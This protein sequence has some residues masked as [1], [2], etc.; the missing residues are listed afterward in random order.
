[1]KFP[2]EARRQNASLV[3]TQY[4]VSPLLKGR[5]ISTVHD[6]SFLVDPYWFTPKDV[7]LLRA[8]VRAAAR[9]CRRIITVSETSKLDIE[10]LV[11]GATGKTDV[12]YNAPSPDVVC[13]VD[14]GIVE[15]ELA[16]LGVR[17]PY[18]L[19][20]GTGWKRKNLSL[21]VEAFCTSEL[22]GPY[23]LIVAGKPGT[24][25]PVSGNVLETGYVTERQLA[26]LYRGAT[27]YLAPSLYE[28][29]GIT[30]VEAMAAGCPV[31][32]SSGGAQPEIAGDAAIVVDSFEPQAWR[33]V[34]EEAVRNGSMLEDLRSRGRHRAAD[35]CWA[36]SARKTASIYREV[37][38][39]LSAP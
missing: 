35:F 6:V 1:M 25:L 34:M 38:G 13:D 23:Q 29:F 36:D 33:K 39:S 11:P 24:P 22:S 17:K 16:A 9:Y 19:T 31:V 7:T 21:A 2:L 3:H 30:I 20:A 37:I 8:G 32:C 26:A 15:E 28:G 12:V 10:A 27:L 18:L 5:S 14:A 4:S